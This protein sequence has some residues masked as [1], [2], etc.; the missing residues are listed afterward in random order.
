MGS[1]LTLG[2]W[3]LLRGELLEGHVTVEGGRVV[4]AEEGPGAARAD[5]EGIV[6]PG[7][8]DHHTH[9]GDAAV[10]P[11]PQGATVADVF[12]PP[13]GYKHRMLATLPRDRLVSGMAAYLERMRAFGVVEHADF[14]E[15]GVAGVGMLQQARGRAALPPTSR[16]WGRPSRQ[17]FDRGELDELLPRVHGLGLSAARDWEWGA[18]R[19]TVAHARAAGRPVAL[20]CSEVERE[21]LS[22]VLE[23]GPDHL[24]HMVHATAQDLRDLAAARVPVAVCPRSVGR[25]GLRPPVLEMRRAGVAILLG[26]DNAMLQPPDVL[27]EVA[28][29][30]RDPALAAQVPPLEALSW[31]LPVPV[32]KTSYTHHDIG[33]RI[34]APDLALFPSAGDQ[35]T[36]LLSQGRIGGA[37]LVMVE[38]RIWRR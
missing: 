32:A 5:M 35:P 24:V 22:R 37:S 13:G 14:R 30:L 4:E 3:V 8:C 26:T 29:L 33:V 19:D 16:V 21:D 25:F 10:P 38:G 31:A 12:A 11:P 1:R 7:L 36:D 23:L 20:H 28:W 18:L 34:G 17:A 6:L 9:A 15:G 27:A 2:G